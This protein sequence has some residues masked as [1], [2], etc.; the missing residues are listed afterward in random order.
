MT[1]KYVNKILPK[2]S[3]I[4][5][6]NI[7]YEIENNLDKYYIR[8][9]EEEIKDQSYKTIDHND[10]KIRTIPTQDQKTIKKFNQFRISYNEN[11]EY[12]NKYKISYGNP[13]Y[14]LLDLKKVIDIIELKC[15]IT[16]RHLMEIIFYLKKTLDRSLEIHNLFINPFN[17]IKEEKQILSYQIAEKICNSLNINITFEEKCI[18]WSYYHIIHKYNSFYVN[19]NKFYEDFKQLC[20]TNKK[21]ISDYLKIMNTVIIRKNIEG[22]DYCT[23]Q[24][25]YELEKNLSYKFVDLITQKHS[26]MEN[27]LIE[28]YI[29]K[30]ED[31]MSNINNKIYLLGDQQ[32]KAIKNILKNSPCIITGFPGT[33]KSSII[34]GVLYILH[35]HK[36]EE[37]S[38]FSD[39]DSDSCL[40]EE[41]L[42]IIVES[43]KL[44]KN[45]NLTNINN[46]QNKLCVNSDVSLISPT[47]LAYVNI[48]KKCSY[49]K[50]DKT[51]N[52]YNPKISGTCHKTLYNI[53]PHI[54]SKIKSKLNKQKK[55]YY[56]DNNV[57]IDDDIIIPKII[58]VDEF[59]M[60]DIFM[61]KELIDFCELFDAHLI[62]VGD[63][64]QLPS[65]GPG[66]LLNSIM[67]TEQEYELFCIT[68]LTKIKRQDGGSLLKNIIKMTETSL[69]IGDFIDESM[70]FINISDL[71]DINN[72]IN[73]EKLYNFIDLQNINKNNSKFLS[74]FNGENEKSKSHPTNVLELNKIIQKRFNDK[75]EPLPKRRFDN[76]NFRINDIIIRT[77]ND[78]HNEPF[79]ANGEQAIIKRYDED[80]VYIKYLD[81]I[82]EDNIDEDKIEVEKFYNEFKLAYA[83][84][85]HKSQGSQYKNIIIFIEKNSYVWDKPA[86]YTAI[87]RAEEKC[88]IISDY[89]EFVK[90]QKKIQNSKKPTLFL[91]ELEQKYSFEI[92]N[93]DL[94]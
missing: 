52:L 66:C 94:I 16:H 40:S 6:N 17:F 41:S 30:F 47:G 48:S 45:N 77:E 90:V 85:V 31:Y 2:N 15:G 10:C 20:E 7:Y 4:I 34:Q 74:Y 62:L 53:F 92:S 88:F 11:I 33:G 70:Q 3:V 65:I 44:Y 49:I 57:D 89:N 71:L 19:P 67:E 50:D 14:I 60:M 5:Y 26:K 64:N 79:R 22:E 39:D 55:S 32:K 23:T 9:L 73:Q 24:Y 38:I 87:S 82:D 51:V 76:F 54:K 93:A 86:L 29:K 18:K 78:S 68:K 59:S 36:C 84:T 27:S 91:K 72:T 37:I 61:F 81:N 12:F 35:L 21:K 25:L 58:I 28:E 56:D 46:S 80:N 75:G 13:K 8:R 43:D 42:S 69:S 63:H 1:T 83:L